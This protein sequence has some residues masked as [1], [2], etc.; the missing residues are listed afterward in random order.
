[1]TIVTPFLERPEPLPRAFA[2]KIIAR[3]PSINDARST[4]R[5]RRILRAVVQVPASRRERGPRFHVVD[6]DASTRRLRKVTDLAPPKRPALGWGFADRFK[7]ADDRTLLSGARFRAQ[8]VYAIAARTLAVFGPSCRPDALVHLT[9]VPAPGI[10]P[11]HLTFMNN[12][13]GTWNVVTAAQR[14][15]RFLTRVN[16]GGAR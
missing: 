16:R 3:D 4:D 9:A 14:T 13:D 8:N 12:I 11:D 2:L 6:F 10:V 15:G 5:D 7:D 1:M